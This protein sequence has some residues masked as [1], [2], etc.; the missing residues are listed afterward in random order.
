MNKSTLNIRFLSKLLCL[1]I[2]IL[3][4]ND[5]A[6][7]NDLSTTYSSVLSEILPAPMTF[8]PVPV[9]KDNY[10]RTGISL[11][12]R[13]DY[14][15]YGET[16]KGCKWDSID[17]D[18][19]AEYRQN[20]N[21][22][23]YERK[24]FTLRRQLAALV[25]AEIVEYKG[26]FIID[27]TK[28]LHYFIHE[29]WW[30]IPAHYPTAQPKYDNQIV[31]LFNAETANLLAWTT[32]ML[33]DELENVELGL[34]EKI[35][36]EI[37]R[38]MLIPARTTN[39]GWKK[40]T[41]N[42]NTWICSNWL[43]CVLF[44][45]NERDKQIDAVTQI[46]QCLDLFYDS[47]PQ[48]GGCEEGI[49]YWDRAAA[50]L[51]ESLYLFELATGEQTPLKNQQKLRN[52]GA[53]VYNTYVG[54]DT[55]V[56][57]SDATPKSNIKPNI[58]LPFAHYI[59]DPLLAGYAI[60]TATNHSFRKTPSKL[61]KQS[62]NYPTLSRELLFLYQYDRYS[63]IQPEEPL[64]QDVW[65]P[66]LQVFAARQ[67]EGS[68]TGLYVAAKGGNN[69]ESH[70]HNDVG[71]FVV[72][73]D[74]EPII[75]DIGNG[76]YTAQTFSNRRYELFNCRSAYHNVPLING[77]EQHEGKDFLATDVKYK[78]N[79]KQASMTLDIAQAY[80]QEAG[81][82]TW[83]RTIQLNRGKD[84]TIIEDYRLIQYKEPTEL[85]MICC[86][87]VKLVE[88]NKIAIN[89]GVKTCYLHFNPH[90]L[91]PAIEKI[92]YQ[93]NTIFN[94]WQKRDLYRIK[95]AIKSHT[96][97]GRITYTIK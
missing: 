56:S 96:L 46:L 43:S 5:V 48:D 78:N 26:R 51:F 29:T 88:S 23:N 73:Y 24:S 2:I 61:F 95:L 57:F 66:T 55:F 38:R 94:A 60:R 52:M 86:G 27:I 63:D 3:F 34:C 37:E 67:S 87:E 75:I 20:G 10:W 47:S 25:L 35:R 8:A 50:S 64:R 13:N 93:D 19:F 4:P 14:I 70:N 32:Y 30:G 36:S 40:K 84:V 82:S 33:H 62:G 9:A 41:D 76:T 69:N 7:N 15:K 72:Y 59:N 28:G 54:N 49:S 22:T 92:I 71:N 12:I 42:W 81:V 91:S 58:A 53:F 79:D 89:N 77:Y 31:D 80:P 90:Q 65:M 39:Y 16:Y 21:R 85:I 17:N 1:S 6:G 45:E 11:E 68:S 97:K 18:L 83:K 44:C 74:A